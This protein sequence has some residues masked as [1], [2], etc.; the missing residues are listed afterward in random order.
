MKRVFK[1]IAKAILGLVLLGF[2]LFTGFKTIEYIKGN[3]FISYLKVNSEAANLDDQLNFSIADD[4]IDRKKMIL[5]GE[6]H[7]FK[8]PTRF[9]PEFFNFLHN[10]HQVQ[11]YLI[12]MDISQAYFMNKY[13]QF[14]DEN[15]LRR[16]LENWVVSIGRENLD[17]RNKWRALREIYI[18]GD[19][20]TYY[21]NNNISDI[22]LL[23]DYINE[24]TNSNI[25]IPKDNKDSVRLSSLKEAIN[26]IN[27][28]NH[29]QWEKKYILR[30]IDF[31][32][33]KKYREEVLTENLI[34]IYE[35]NKLQERKVFGYYGLGHI[36]LSPLDD[37]YESMASRFSKEMP[38][39]NNKILSFGM[40]FTDSYM[41][42][43][44]TSLPSFLRNEGKFTALPVSYDNIWL[45]YLHGIN[46]LKR[47]TEESSKTLIKLNG[48]KSP[49]TT[50][51]RLTTMSK[52]LPIGATINGDPKLATTD[53]FQY[54]ILIRNSREAVGIEE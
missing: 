1:I 33:N 2:L 46:E 8:E 15:I 11:D 10:A 21:G 5:V 45:S 41:T 24:I 38:D 39:M 3:P 52:I 4:D 42:T 29:L 32:I 13:N 18:K 51:R 49:Y 53:Y 9:E 20:F 7:G 48:K 37:G 28:K 23:V 14:G 12:E 19:G 31:A 43:Y 40:V 36:F 26:Q 34:S 16:I 54:L 30:N 50:S 17:Y 27:W 22:D 6:V 44:S 47:I 35:Y 25:K